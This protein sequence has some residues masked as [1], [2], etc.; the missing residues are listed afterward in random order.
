MER[1]LT[2]VLLV[3]HWDCSWDSLALHLCLV[4]Y[5]KYLSCVINSNNE[6]H[7]RSTSFSRILQKSIS[8]EE[9]LYKSSQEKINKHVCLE[10]DKEGS[11]YCNSQ[12]VHISKSIHTFLQSVMY[13]YLP[14]YDLSLQLNKLVVIILFKQ[15]LSTL[16]P[17]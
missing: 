9:M 13:Q 7:L 15:H 6:I 1:H 3:D 14:T 2:L 10:N 5:K 11:I 8:L 17:Y 16:D 12:A 4:V